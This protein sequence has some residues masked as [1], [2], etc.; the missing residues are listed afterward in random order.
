MYDD[1]NEKLATPKA[2]PFVF[3]RKRVW[4]PKSQLELDNVYANSVLVEDWLVKSK[5]LEEYT[6]G[7]EL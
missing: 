4:L 1:I 3:G 2:I 5:R 7:K 6:W